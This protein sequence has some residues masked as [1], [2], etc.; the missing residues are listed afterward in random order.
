MNDNRQLPVG[1]LVLGASGYVAGELLRWLAGHPEMRLAGA[2][3]ASHAGLPIAESF[4]NL[5]AAFGD[6]T[7]TAPG[8]LPRT[9]ERAAGEHSGLAAFSA[10]PHKASAPQVAALIEAADAVGCELPVV[11]LSADFRHS[12]PAR[13]REIYGIPHPAPEL[14]R[15]F[16]CGLTELTPDASQV[17]G[18]AGPG[19][20]AHP[21]CFA[22][23]AALAVAPLRRGGLVEPDLHVSAVTGSTGSGGMP[24]ETTHH[25]LRHANLFAYKP[26]RHRHA[27]EMEDLLAVPGEVA[28]KVRFVPHSGPFA[29]GIHATVFARSRARLTDDGLDQVFRDFYANAPLVRVAAAPRLKETVG[30]ATTVVGAATDGETVVAFAAL[31]NLGKGAASGGV[32]WMNRLLGFPEETGLTVPTP[33]WL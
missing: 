33:A 3:S 29:R 23:A 28:A 7:F 17:D 24:R 25:P 13:Y 16:T 22:T 10:A 8:D 2:V 6:Q 1:A 4:P 30:S 21:G 32:Q 18:G 31:D 27:P 11:D 12:D 20:V 19:R 26:L 5:A 9:L 14:L 15:E